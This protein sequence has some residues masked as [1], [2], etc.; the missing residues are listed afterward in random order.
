MEW[1]WFICTYGGQ[2]LT[3]MQGTRATVEMGSPSKIVRVVSTI[4]RTT[5]GIRSGKPY[6]TG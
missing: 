1:K 6:S 3:G 4:P 2:E 5:R